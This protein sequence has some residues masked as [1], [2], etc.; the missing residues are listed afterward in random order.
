MDKLYSSII[1]SKTGF[2]IPVFS[3]NKPMHSKYDPIKEAQTIIQSVS[4]SDFYIILGLGSGFIPKILKENQPDCNMII[5]ENSVKDIEFLLTGIK[6][7]KDFISENKII[8]TTISQIETALKQYF[9]PIFYNSL[10]VIEV[11]SWMT[12]LNEECTNLINQINH[13][14]D[15]ILR[16]YSTQVHFGK[17]WQ[18]NII[19]NLKL[20]TPVKPSFNTKKTAYI[21]GAGPSLDEKIQEIKENIKNIC[22]ISTDT[23][24]STLKKNNIN[25]DVICSL[26][27]QLLSLEHFKNNLNPL[28]LFVFDLQANSSAA[29]KIKKEKGNILFTKSNH[30]LVSYCDFNNSFNFLYSGSGTVTI[31]AIDLALK[32]GFKTIKIIGADFSYPYNKPYAKGTYLDSVYNEKSLRINTSQTNYAGL[33]YKTEL[34][35]NDFGIKTT[36]LLQS[37]KNSFENWIQNQNLSF[38]Y[39]DSIYTINN[40]NPENNFKETSFSYDT[41]SV[42]LKNDYKRLKSNISINNSNFNELEIALLPYIAYLKNQ[43]LK[44]Q[45]NIQYNELVKLALQN[46][47]RYT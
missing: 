44:T 4:K 30:P 32:A 29:K 18:K 9:L 5:I 37:Y 25:P 39:H 27:G 13:T 11:R 33:M 1:E 36:K 20:F 23:A 40:N 43:L 19:D 46:I 17:I 6:G 45:K 26:D 14:L 2:E 21:I 16:D 42:K 38:D 15:E 3:N 7:L 24:Y 8:L 41:F 31:M 28:P 35:F 34:I 10:S 12:E 22:I 47:V